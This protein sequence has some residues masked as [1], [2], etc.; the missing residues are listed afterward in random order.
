MGTIRAL[1]VPNR[2]TQQG[3]GGN[4]RHSAPYTLSPK[5]ANLCLQ[6]SAPSPFPLA[7]QK[8]RAVGPDY[9]IGKVWTFPSPFLLQNFPP[10]EQFRPAGQM[11]PFEHDTL[12]QPKATPRPALIAHL[13]MP[14][15]NLILQGV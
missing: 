2:V 15:V 11:W 8:T 4:D 14:R 6:S 1:D 12:E 3:D 13:I 9:S 5:V 7:P 10:L